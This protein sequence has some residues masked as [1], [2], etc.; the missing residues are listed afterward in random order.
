[1][2]VEIRPEPSAEERAAIEAVVAGLLA[3]QGETHSVWWH[4]GLL[5]AVENDEPELP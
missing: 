3:G 2:D 1:M 5:D 4:A